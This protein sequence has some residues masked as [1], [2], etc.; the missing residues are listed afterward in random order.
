MFWFVCQPLNIVLERV[1]HM[2]KTNFQRDVS[3]SVGNKKKYTREN[4]VATRLSHMTPS[5]VHMQGNKISFDFDRHRLNYTL[6]GRGQV[7][8]VGQWSR[9]RPVLFYDRKL[10]NPQDVRLL[11]V[12]EGVE[13]YAAQQYHLD[14]QIAAHYVATNA[15]HRLAN[16]THRN[17]D[18][19]S[20]RVE[21][22]YR[23]NEMQRRK[24]G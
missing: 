23:M 10:T 16:R 14:P 11:A 13:K 3:Q 7:K 4:Q 15:E 22:V 9:T 2:G 5:N 21:F 1:S 6:Q 19:Y 18:D 8:D 24:R 12:H 20:M 17:W